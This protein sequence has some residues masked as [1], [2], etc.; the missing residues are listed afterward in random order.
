MASNHPSASTYKIR[1]R[2][3]KKYPS[4]ISNWSDWSDVRT[5]KVTTASFTPNRGDIIYATHYNNAKALIDRVRKTYNVTWNNAP[6]NVVA[7]TTKILRTQYPY[8]NWYDRIV[9]TKN[10]VNN[11]ATFDSGQA[12]VKFD[13]SNAILTN[14]TAV[15]ELVTAASNESVT[16]GTGRNYMKIVYDR[17]NRLV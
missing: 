2:V 3:K 16:T 15:V 7:K 4:D 12:G 1:V 8:I 5:I 10:Q 14:F 9:A 17:C 6:A 11:Y 13:N